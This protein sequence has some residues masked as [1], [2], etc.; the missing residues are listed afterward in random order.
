MIND[1]VKHSVQLFTWESHCN[2]IL[3]LRMFKFFSQF[4][5]MVSDLWP[6]RYL[7]DVALHH[8]I[9]ALCKLS[10]EAMDLAY[11]N[12]V[13]SCHVWPHSTLHDDPP[14]WFQINPQIKVVVFLYKLY[15]LFVP[16]IKYYYYNYYSVRVVLLTL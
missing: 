6:C 16:E 10:S 1:L 15:G 8:L 13:S 4:M 12:Q 3:K 14:S 7:D 5:L 11:S 9:D 2:N